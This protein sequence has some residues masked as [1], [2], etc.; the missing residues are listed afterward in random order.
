M[1]LAACSRNQQINISHSNAADPNIKYEL[2]FN[3]NI[4]YKLTHMQEISWT[5]ERNWNC[6]L[7]P[8]LVS[9][10][11]LKVFSFFWDVRIS[12]MKWFI[13]HESN[14]YRIQVSKW[15]VWATELVSWKLST[16]LKSEICSFLMWGPLIGYAGI[17]FIQGRGLLC[18]VALYHSLSRS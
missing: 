15:F 16:D 6:Y 13:F 12:D 4:T 5:V 11:L 18:S 10:A 7:K 2:Y 3:I 1:L 14:H 17:G 8:K 9:S